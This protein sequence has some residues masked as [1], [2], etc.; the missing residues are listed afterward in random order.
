MKFYLDPIDQFLGYSG[1][2]AIGLLDI[3]F[4]S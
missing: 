4:A 3:V 1:E 2:L